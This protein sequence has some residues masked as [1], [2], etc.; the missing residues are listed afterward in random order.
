[1]EAPTMSNFHKKN[2]EEG[3]LAEIKIKTARG[4]EIIASKYILSRSPVFDAMLN[5]HDTKEAREGVIKITDI[6]HNVLTEMIRY[7]YYDEIPKLKEMALDLLVAGNKYDLPGLV[8]ATESYLRCNISIANF[9]TILITADK[10]NVNGL[11]DTAIKFIIE[12]NA[13]VFDTADWKS[14]K[15]NHA[16]LTFE[17]TEKII[18]K[19]YSKKDK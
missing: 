3:K 7:M 11:K 17:I 12:N 13:A 9:A 4:K 15:Q 19:L 16:Q 1:M 18:Q 10:S 6:N 2:F 8:A 5:R 14:L